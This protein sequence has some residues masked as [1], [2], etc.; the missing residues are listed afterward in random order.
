[1]S[2]PAGVRRCTT[3]ASSLLVG[4]VLSLGGLGQAS[5]EEV[6]ADGACVDLE[7][8]T[9]C[10]KLRHDRTMRTMIPRAQGSSG[11]PVVTLGFRFQ[12]QRSCRS[13]DGEIVVNF[14]LLMHGISPPVVA[15]YPD[16]M[17]Q[18]LP[19]SAEKE[20]YRI[21]DRVGIIVKPEVGLTADPSV[22]SSVFGI[23]GT[24]FP[25][26][27]LVATEYVTV[28]E[29]LAACRAHGESNDE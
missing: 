17:A 20:R 10:H 23:D 6:A 21:G 27:T 18:I 14:R 12:G 16:L 24:A 8:S 9:F 26:G 29:A 7:A 1:M 2:T 28:A 5:A 15:D 3:C 4:L 11:P 19:S 13:A 25:D 22:L